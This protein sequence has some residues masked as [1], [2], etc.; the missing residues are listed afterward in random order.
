MLESDNLM[1][2]QSN[3]SKFRFSTNILKIKHLSSFRVTK[4]CTRLTS[5][6]DLLLKNN[7]LIFK[8]VIKNIY[9]AN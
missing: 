8:T 2:R 9:S 3:N 5:E 7:N 1:K 4:I 6:S